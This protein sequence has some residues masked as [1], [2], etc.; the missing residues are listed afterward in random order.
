MYS[1]DRLPDDSVKSPRRADR[2]ARI[3]ISRSRDGGMTVG[4]MDITW[5]EE[6][7]WAESSGA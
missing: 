5:D 2:C 4:S 3:V 7:N 6:R 1:E